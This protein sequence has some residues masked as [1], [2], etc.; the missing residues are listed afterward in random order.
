MYRK[1]L[2]LKY[3]TMLMYCKQCVI[4]FTARIENQQKY[5]LPISEIDAKVGHQTFIVIITQTK[6]LLST[7]TQTLLLTSFIF[8]SKF[9]FFFN[10][11]FHFN[12]FGKLFINHKF[13]T[14]INQ[15]INL[16]VRHHKYDGYRPIVSPQMI[17]TCIQ[18]SIFISF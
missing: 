13:Y 16:M 14:I 7:A 12:W 1:A 3:I 9:F 5:I 6:C 18:F 17:S 10:L 15:I 4:A 8:H 11:Y 2:Y